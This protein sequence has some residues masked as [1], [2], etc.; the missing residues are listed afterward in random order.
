MEE[1]STASLTCLLIRLRF[2]SW[3]RTRALRYAGLKGFVTYAS[4]PSS[5]PWTWFSMAPMAVTSTTGIWQSCRSRLIER[6][7]SKP[8]FSG[9]ATSL[10]IMSGWVSFARAS[11]SSVELAAA[12][13]YSLENRL[14]R[15][16]MISGSSSTA[17]NNGNLSTLSEMIFVSGMADTVSI[18][19]R[20][21]TEASP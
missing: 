9:I 14:N 15:Y 7:S 3:E 5:R 20:P 6:H 8:S 2:S 18:G 11:A 13:L 19:K 12:N 21:E 1:L 4:A 16:L 10:K 17:S